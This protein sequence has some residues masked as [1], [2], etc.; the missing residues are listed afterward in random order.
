MKSRTVLISRNAIIVSFIIC[1]F[2]LEV[3]FAG[4]ENKV[5]KDKAI[6]HLHPC[7]SGGTKKT[8]FYVGQEAKDGSPIFNGTVFLVQYDG[9]PYAVTAK[10]VV[11]GLYETLKDSEFTFFLNQVDGTGLQLKQ[12]WIMRRTGGKWLLSEAADI[13]VMPFLLSD[14]FD[15]RLIPL[16]FFVTSDSLMELEDAF[17]ISYQPGVES[18]GRITPI[19]RSGTISIINPDNSFILDAF[20]FPGN[21]GSPVFIKPSIAYDDISVSQ[22]CKFIGVVSS[23]LPYRDVAISAQT[24]QPRIIFEENTGLAYITAVQALQDLF[25]TEEFKKQHYAF[26]EHIKQFAK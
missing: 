22:G 9:H 16:D 17:Y 5:P 10:H 7:I 6:K 2:G 14:N 24:K 20:V 4:E 21:S 1:L 13:A 12:D 18:P 25:K 19:V 26:K 8:V 15:L 11:A 23:Y 3:T